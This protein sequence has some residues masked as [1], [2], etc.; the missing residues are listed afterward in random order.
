M[1]PTQFSTLFAAV[2]AFAWKGAVVLLV[3][4]GLASLLGRHSAAA[5][6]LVWCSAMVALLAL[7]V[8]ASLVP[9]WRAEL[10]LLAA[11]GPT[12]RQAVP[13]VA[14]EFAAPVVLAQPDVN[15]VASADPAMT[16]PV[17]V[18]VVT[19]PVL[20]EPE[21]AET[22]VV[23]P[24][25]AEPVD[26]EPV[27]DVQRSTVPGLPTIL[28]FV[29]AFGVVVVAGDILVGHVIARA[30]TRRSGRVTEPDILCAADAAAR[31]L[32]LDRPVDL[33]VSDEVAVPCTWGLFR[34]VVLLPDEAFAWS[35]DR[36]RM[37]LTHELGH[38][39]R[40]DWVTQLVSHV[41][42]SLH[43]FNPLAWI[44]RRRVIAEQEAATDDLVLYCGDAARDYAN[45]LLDI[46]RSSL[47]SRNRFGSIATATIAMS[48]RST[49]EGRLLAILDTDRRRA[50]VFAKR[51][52]ITA[53]LAV[54]AL[55]PL[56]AIHPAAVARADADASAGLFARADVASDARVDAASPHETADRDQVEPVR[57]AMPAQSVAVAA[58]ATYPV[59][60][61]EAS[62]EVHPEASPEASPEAWPEEQPDVLANSQGNSL[63]FA[64]PVALPERG[65]ADSTK[66]LAL[67]AALADESEADVRVYLV[68]IL[69]QL[70]NRLATTGLAR[71]L[72]NDEDAEVRATAAWAL[73]ELE[74]PASL[75]ALSS[76]L[77][78]DTS[79]QVRRHAVMAISEIGS[80]ES[81]P[82][83]ERALV[84]DESV[85]VREHAAWALGEIGYEAA[86][87]A[88][89]KALSDT[90]ERVRLRAAYSLGE[91][92]SAS[93]A[94]L[95]VG[96]LGDSSPKVRA[97]AARALAEIAPESAVG[98]LS[99]V[100]AD[101]DQHVRESAIYALGEIGSA[102]AVGA[103]TRALSDSEAN[104]RARAA[105][106]LAEIGSPAA[107]D[108][109]IAALD[110]EDADVRSHVAR[111]LGE[112]KA[113]AAA[114]ALLRLLRND[115]DSNVRKMAA[116][117]LSELD[118]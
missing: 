106:A 84:N 94:S 48:R 15:V 42:C 6:H 25:I 116:M 89:E 38:I 12:L 30:I 41:A 36:V 21:V 86:V 49:L 29:W 85:E 54:V 112:S 11:E 92:G 43:W 60:R 110:D 88:L 37:V 102:D 4:G 51:V 111:A 87:T 118:F 52:V 44:A 39:K 114:D 47:G 23:E 27:V 40:I 93:S 72:V 55:L 1:E 26:V 17:D 45:S 50:P 9:T 61:P 96:L 5:R 63:S 16:I 57:D 109:L 22:V 108:A 35:E 81:G 10:P 19:S 99:R 113:H 58:P 73:A 32:S 117:A 77:T 31:R 67:L 24:V 28:L 82:V 59:A 90:S 78:N 71:V 115:P 64:A 18:P 66:V 34:P 76:A 105:W 33:R 68:R 65:A 7:P 104:V 53:A 14:P 101:Q 8:V 95:L 62:P 2:G 70:E 100:V 13:V 103:L 56:A 91:I 74:D 80:R 97:Y 83:L 79:E 98:P 20:V 46:A 69:G 75:T 3:A 107:Q